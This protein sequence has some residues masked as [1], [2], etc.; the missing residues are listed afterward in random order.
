MKRKPD[1]LAKRTAQAQLEGA[2]ALLGG[3][4]EVARYDKTVFVRRAGELIARAA[5]NGKRKSS[6]SKRGDHT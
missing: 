5:M 6:V 2:L 3:H 1:S 4:N